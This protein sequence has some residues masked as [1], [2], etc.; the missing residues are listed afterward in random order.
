MKNLAYIFILLNLFFCNGQSTNKKVENK[1]IENLALNI[2]TTY[3]KINQR[4]ISKTW[5]SLNAIQKEWIK[6]EKD[7]DGF[8]I[9][10]PC[11]G[12]TETI[13]FENGNILINWRIEGEK[14]NY[15]KFT[16]KTGNT[17]FR[18]DASGIESKQNFEINAKIVDYKN[19]IVLW[20]FDG[21]KWFMTP[22]E[23]YKSFRIIKNNCETEKKNELEFK[24]IEDYK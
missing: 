3:P 17:S 23:N 20:E 15:E 8:L 6:V 19:G 24:P 21:I 11:D 9:Y 1:Q 14:F 5:K 4:K 2:T 13:K 22:R 18:L 10:E 12:N 16:R 7:K